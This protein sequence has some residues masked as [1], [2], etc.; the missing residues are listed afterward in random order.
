MTDRSSVEQ[1]EPVH[2]VLLANQPRMFREMLHRALDR[3]PG[4]RLTLEATD[5]ERLPEILARV[6]AD[7][8]IVTLDEQ[9]TLP[10]P[11]QQIVAQNP[12]LSVVGISVDGE[13]LEIQKV[14]VAKEDMEHR[15][16]S[17]DNITLSELLVILGV[18]G[19]QSKED[20]AQSR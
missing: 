11:I 2:I 3:A 1:N 12:T 13:H 16:L 8:L 9:S 15:W 20:S 5:L 17:L 10:G 4:V 18:N 6:Q 7:W 14:R 19:A